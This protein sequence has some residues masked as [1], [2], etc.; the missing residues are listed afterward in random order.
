MHTDS[1]LIELEAKL[2]AHRRLLK[3]LIQQLAGQ[4]ANPEKSWAECADSTMVEEAKVR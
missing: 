1:K 3:I 4:H 2:F